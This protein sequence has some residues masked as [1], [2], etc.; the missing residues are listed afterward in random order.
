MIQTR[1]PQRPPHAVSQQTAAIPPT[2]LS[3]TAEFGLPET[4]V[5]I[6]KRSF[7]LLK[8]TLDVLLSCAGLALFSPL[9]GLAA[10]AVRIDSPGPVFIKQTRVGRR[11]KTFG[12]YKFR[13][14]KQDAEQV[15]QSLEHLNE[16]NGPVFKIK[17]DPRITRLG[18]FIRKYSV[19]EIPQLLNVIRGEMS[20]VGP[21][22]PLPCEVA[23]YEPRFLRRLEVTPGITGLQQLNARDDHNFE[24]WVYWD[25]RYIE[26]QNLLLDL[27]I[28]AC[29]PLA[30]ITA[31]GA[32]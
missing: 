12:M 20:L 11:G 21:R 4:G 9:I 22:P 5:S 30:V 7:R 23:M 24:N 16:R 28:L 29:T 18:R 6:G 14:M 26:N 32:S 27:W 2:V 31:R 25:V 8:R 17:N 10:L 3:T 1:F 19:D 15:R 13:S